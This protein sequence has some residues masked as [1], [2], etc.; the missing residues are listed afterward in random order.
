M[1]VKSR[2]FLL[3]ELFL[4][5]ALISLSVIPLA[6]YPFKMYQK[7]IS[8][9]I[10]MQ[11]EETAEIAFRDLLLDLSSYIDPETFD[12][13]IETPE[14]IYKIQLTKKYNWNYVANWKLTC[15]PT[16]EENPTSAFLKADLTLVPLDKQ[17]IFVKL[18]PLKKIRYNYFI[19]KKP[20]ASQGEA[21]GEPETL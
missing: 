9:L 14:K 16:K 11:L 8:L 2:P 6:S 3:L 5:L 1:I 15:K 7:E 20:A 13:F 17:G 18:P 12:P 4:A 21:N 10:E 19:E